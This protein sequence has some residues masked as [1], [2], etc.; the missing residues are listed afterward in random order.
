MTFFL[1]DQH[2]VYVG[3]EDFLAELRHELQDIQ[4][5]QGN[6]II[7][8]KNQRPV[9][10]LDIWQ[11]PVSSN[12]ISIG[13]AAK[14]LKSIQG[15]WYPHLDEHRGRTMLIADK[16]PSVKRFMTPLFPMTSRPSIGA[17]TLL[18]RDVLLYA[19]Q[20]EKPFPDGIFNVV[21]DKIHPPNR[22][23]LK[24]WEALSV[25]GRYP[26][27]GQTA[28]DLGASP[29]GWTYVLASMGAQVTAIDKAPLDKK[30]A[31]LPNVEAKQ[32][33]AFSLQPRDVDPI[34]WWVCDI[35]CYPEKLYGYLL[36]WIE[37][38][39][40]GQ[41][42]VTIKLQGKTDFDILK[43]FQAIPGGRVMHLYQ[44]KHEAT[45]FYPSISQ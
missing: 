7:A 35:A 2:Q 40:V 16:L 17:F 19:S 13:E 14:E 26:E 11:N 34:D 25:L 43:K 3:K 1:N 24:L 36:P 18:D 9:F 6:L 38:G 41:F 30:L 8:A 4:A 44:N 27:A 28:L 33:S 42:I 22:A 29:G 12:I 10:A 39:K 21:E 23:Y 45:F 31:K 37:S 15:F 32:L 20:R 5:E